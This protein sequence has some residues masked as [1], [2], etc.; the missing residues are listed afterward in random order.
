MQYRRLVRFLLDLRLYLFFDLHLC[1]FFHFFPFLFLHLFFFLLFFQLLLEPI[2]L[3]FFVFC[4]FLFLEPILF[5]FLVFC[6]FLSLELVFFLFPGFFLLLLGFFFCLLALRLALVSF[7][8]NLAWMST[9]FYNIPGPV[10]S[11]SES[12]TCIRFIVFHGLL[13]QKSMC[14]LQR[15]NAP[16]SPLWFCLHLCRSWLSLLQTYAQYGPTCFKLH[17]SEFTSR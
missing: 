12:H 4:L 9:G 5:V 6:L 17:K 8:S 7:R 13:L 10:V 11:Q 14:N 2:L 16:P 1:L 15:S 3:V